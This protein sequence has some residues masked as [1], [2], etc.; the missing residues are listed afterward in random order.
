MLALGLAGGV[1]GASAPASSA[2]RPATAMA[3]TGVVDREVATGTVPGAVVAAGDA[4]GVRFLTA[5]G[6]L[7]L[8]PQPR[9]MPED[10]IF[11]LASVTKVVG[12]TT[13]VMLLVDDGKLRL[14]DPLGKHIPEWRDRPA[15]ED[16]RVRHLLTHTSGLPAYLSV[17]PL[18][19]AHGAGPQPDTV[20]AAIASLPLRRPPESGVEYSCLNAIL[21]G[22]LAENCAGMSLQRFLTARVFQPLGMNDTGW[23]LKR[24]QLARLVPTGRTGRLEAEGELPADTPAGPFTAGL[25]HDPL[26]RYYATAERCAGNAGLFSTAADLARFA[27][28]ILGQGELDGVRVLRAET[29]AL[30]TRVQ[31]P[32]GAET[33]GYGWDVWNTYPFQP[34][35]DRP[36]E[37]QAIGHL[38]FTGTMIW[39]DKGSGLWAVVLASRVHGGP[40]ASVTALRR[41]VIQ[42]VVEGA[43]AAPPPPPP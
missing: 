43:A 32:S 11:D 30:F 27:R 42:A 7:Q 1:S 20:I 36:A 19:K 15:G 14:D 37:S 29:V 38:G 39:I 17:A 9:P 6:C 41:A 25:V 8:T 3:I 33:R 12:T 24:A 18:E 5:G 35:Q 23:Q 22:R 16:V 10:A 28:M 40:E 2:W 34:S 4:Q 31:T 13:A 26:A 21:A